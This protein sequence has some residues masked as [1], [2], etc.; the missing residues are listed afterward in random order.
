M[1]TCS[2][3]QAL[4]IEAYMEAVRRFQS[5]KPQARRFVRYARSINRLRAIEHAI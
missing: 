4:A 5:S 2:F 3:F 1:I